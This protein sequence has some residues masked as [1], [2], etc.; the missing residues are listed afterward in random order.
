MKT[1]LEIIEET[2]T[3]YSED[4]SRRASTNG[5]CEYLTL[6]GRMCAV[7]R[8]LIDPGAVVGGGAEAILGENGADKLLKEEYRGHDVNFWVYLQLFHDGNYWDENG[9]TEKGKEFLQMLKEK[10]S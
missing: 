7:G 10:Y 5:M 8:C 6:D 3:Y 9:L 4:T 2:A 1:K